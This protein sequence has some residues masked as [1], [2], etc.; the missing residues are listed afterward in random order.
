KMREANYLSAIH[1]MEYRL[2][3]EIS[4][5]VKEE[6]HRVYRTQVGNYIERIDVL[7]KENSKLKQ[8]NEAMTTK[9]T[10]LEEE[11]A[12]LSSD[13]RKLFSSYNKLLQMD[14]KKNEELREKSEETMQATIAQETWEK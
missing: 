14:L 6:E 9:V 4:R 5:E 10:A 2:R 13:F 3:D 7:K 11:N 12:T 1:E 8:E